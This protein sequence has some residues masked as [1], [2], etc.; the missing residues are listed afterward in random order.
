MLVQRLLC[1]TNY[2]SRVGIVHLLVVEVA[3]AVDDP[4]NANNLPS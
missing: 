3:P 1:L 2:L 4:V